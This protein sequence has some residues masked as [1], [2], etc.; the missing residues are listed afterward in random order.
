MSDRTAGT[1]E[2]AARTRERT[3][4]VT[5]LAAEFHAPSLTDFFPP[6]VLFEGTPFELDRLMLIRILMSAVLIGLMALAFRSPRI[7]PRG[8]QNVAEIGLVFVK[9]QICEEVL[10]KETGRKYFP[11]IATI[12]FTVL[13]LNFSSIVPFLN[14]SSNARIGMPLVLAVIAYIAFN[15][16]GIKKYGFFKYMRSSIVVP[17]VPPALHVLLIPIEFVS[18][19]ILRPFTLTVRLMANMLA[20][21]IMLVLFFSSTWFFLFDAANWM[22][23]FSPFSLLAGIGFTMFEMLVIFLQAYVFA[24]LTAV[25]IGLAEHA[26]SH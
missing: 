26:D 19:F 3:L 13:F 17:N 9:E 11:L 6:A 18:T 22:K 2:P 15:Y 4:S 23:V 5:T 24:L 8:L 20:G 7:V 16:V 25:Y 21:H 10:G 14:I 12:F 1:T